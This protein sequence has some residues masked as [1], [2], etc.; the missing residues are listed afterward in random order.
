MFLSP[1]KTFFLK[2]HRAPFCTVLKKRLDQ[3]ILKEETD[4]E[5]VPCTA[6]HYFY[7]PSWRQELHDDLQPNHLLPSLAPY[8]LVLLEQMLPSLAPS[9]I[10]PI[11][12]QGAGN[13]RYQ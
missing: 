4:N 8:S 7:T 13:E 12:C 5:H 9:E 2:S 11:P 1:S 10:H 6:F 3:M